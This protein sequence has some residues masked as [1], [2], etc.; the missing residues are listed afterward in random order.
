MEK[1]LGMSIGRGFRAQKGFINPNEKR[2]SDGPLLLLLLA[3]SF[4]MVME[5]SRKHGPDI[6]QHTTF[7]MPGS[8]FVSVIFLR[9]C[10]FSNVIWFDENQNQVA[11]G[12]LF[13]TIRQLE[14]QGIHVPQSLR[15]SF[16]LLH[17]YILVRTY[18]RAHQHHHYF[19]ACH[20]TM[21]RV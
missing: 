7:L 2:S 19:C 17:S 20:P 10:A 6:N 12:I 9:R 21:C 13:E 1:S 5:P 16:V 11:H 4:F 14:D 8:Y 15:R 18:W 3:T